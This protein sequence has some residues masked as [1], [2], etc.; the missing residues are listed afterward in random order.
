[1]CNEDGTIWITFNGEIYN[2]KELGNRLRALGHRFK[3]NSDTEVIIHG[4][5]EW[6]IE[7]LLK[8][9][10]GMFAFAIYDSRPMPS[11]PCPKLLIAR[12]P[13][14]IKPLYYADDGKTIRVASQVKA[15]LAGGKIDTSPEP[16]GHVGF[17]L[18]GHIPEPYTLYRGIRSLPAGS[19]MCIHD[20]F[21][22]NSMLSAPGS[23]LTPHVYQN[24]SQLFADA[25]RNPVSLSKEE[26][27][28]RLRAA[29]LDTVQHH[30][31]ADVPVGVFL[32]SGLDSSTLAALASETAKDRLNTV[33]L[34]FREYLGTDN[35]EVPL[36]EQVARHYG[37]L[38]R[39]IW[40]E[41]KDFRTDFDRLFDA[42]DQPTTDGVNSY[43][44]SK[45][46]PRPV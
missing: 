30:L 38:H 9:L 45:A 17:F 12:D 43:F 39:A 10:R 5:E 16:A 20:A 2:Y 25:E 33:T 26:V 28:E 35:D 34:G 1:M 24:V 23:L 15:L 14:G 40:V 46:V 21:S 36:A 3:S 18:W 42:M 6:G 22:S 13:F 27:H 7:D 41:K 32:S 44:V 31:V 37:A 4:Y 19:Y 8:Q 29:L 11:A